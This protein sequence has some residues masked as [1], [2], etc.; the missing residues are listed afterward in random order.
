MDMTGNSYLEAIYIVNIF[1]SDT[2]G[3]GFQPKSEK[4][5]DAD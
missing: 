2:K 3:T 1:D 4:H 5:R